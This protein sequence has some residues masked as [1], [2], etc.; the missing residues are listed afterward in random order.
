MNATETEAL[1]ARLRFH[2]AALSVGCCSCGVKTFQAEW[3]DAGCKVRNA[4]HASD[5]LDILADALEAKDREIERLRKA[6]GYAVMIF[7]GQR[8]PNDAAK[9]RA[10]LQ[11]QMSDGGGDVE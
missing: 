4:A 8:Q 11:H 9:L 10:A 2:I 7:E 5:N 6:V 1:V 3:H